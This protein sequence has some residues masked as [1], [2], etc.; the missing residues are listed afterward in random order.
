MRGAQC[1]IILVLTLFDNLLMGDVFDEWISKS[2]QQEIREDTRKTPI[3]VFKR[4]DLQEFDDEVRD[5]EKRVK[6]LFFECFSSPEDK[7]AHLF[8]C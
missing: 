7:F 3:A 4:M 2:K 5:D 6:T 1:E 8:G